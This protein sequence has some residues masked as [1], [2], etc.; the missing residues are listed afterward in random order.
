[1]RNHAAARLVTGWI[2]HLSTAALSS[3]SSSSSSSQREVK[4]LAMCFPTAVDHWTRLLLGSVDGTVNLVPDLEESARR[5]KQAKPDVLLFVDLP[6]DWRS[7]ALAAL[8]LADVQ[9]AFWGHAHSSHLASVDYFV[10]PPGAAPQVT[11]KHNHLLGSS[12]SDHYGGGSGGSSSHQDDSSFETDEDGEGALATLHPLAFAARVAS[13]G[14]GGRGSGASGIGCGSQ[15]DACGESENQCSGDDQEG[16]GVGGS[17]ASGS[18]R[19]RAGVGSGGAT[20]GVGGGGAAVGSMYEASALGL[21][22]AMGLRLPHDGEDPKAWRPQGGT[23]HPLFR[24]GYDGAPAAVHLLGRQLEQPVLL[25]SSGAGT[26]YDPLLALKLELEPTATAATAA[27]SRASS[28]FDTPLEA[29]RTSVDDDS[30]DDVIK[31]GII[32]ASSSER[33]EENTGANKRKRRKKKKKRQEK[34]TMEPGAKVKGMGEIPPSSKASPSSSASPSS[35]DE[36]LFDW[37]VPYDELKMKLH[38]PESTAKTSRSEMRKSRSKSDAAGR[39]ATTTTTAAGISTIGDDSTSSGSIFPSALAPPAYVVLPLRTHQW[40]PELDHAVAK[41]LLMSSRPLSRKKKK[42]SRKATLFAVPSHEEMEKNHRSGGKEEK[43]RSKPEGVEDQEKRGLGENGGEIGGDEGVQVEEGGDDGGPVVHVV[44]VAEWTLV[45]G[46]GEGDAMTRHDIHQQASPVAWERRL[47]Q[48]LASRLPSKLRKALMARVHWLPPLE[49]KDY[50]SVLRHARAALDTFPVANPVGCLDAMSVGTPIVTAPLLQREGFRVGASL[51][52]GLLAECPLQTL[53]ASLARHTKVLSTSAAAAAANT[54]KG[55]GQRK[56]EEGEGGVGSGYWLLPP[57]AEDAAGVA[58][59]ALN[60]ADHR[61]PW[62]SH[63]REVLVACRGAL[64]NDDHYAQDLRRFLLNA[65]KA[66]KPAGQ[67]YPA[68]ALRA[69]RSSADGADG[70]S[71]EG[72][73]GNTREH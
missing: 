2:R 52:Q 50:L 44:V 43:R 9:V 63:L 60:L 15:P 48:R 40:H 28:L 8:R 23:M 68:S 1:M 33:G 5:I 24:N 65:A 66:A 67:L 58:R 54:R 10:L 31:S 46:T 61:N 37:V 38:L 34:E 14:G 3:S 36:D 7:Y 6:L 4:T 70:A 47:K 53:N 56:G 16:S 45:E 11:A 59:A 71:S 32:Y 62:G 73:D 12:S 64:F 42:K 13:I 22:E 49:A 27:T 21:G 18:E 69:P 19:R 17:G 57:M 20:V 29:T 39:N 72:G 30:E 41:L 26:F 51:W 55:Q 35:L 25:G